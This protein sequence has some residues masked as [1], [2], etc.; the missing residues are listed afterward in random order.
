MTAFEQIQ[1]AIIDSGYTMRHDLVDGVHRIYAPAK[2]TGET[3]GWLPD[4]FSEMPE[5]L[6]GMVI[7]RQGVVRYAEMLGKIYPW[8]TPDSVTR[9]STDQM[10]RR[11]S[12]NPA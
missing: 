6:V 10:V 1:D 7:V 8:W 4:G 9:E 2:P 5:M 3:L 11:I 12:E